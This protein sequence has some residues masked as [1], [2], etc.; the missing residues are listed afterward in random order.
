MRILFCWSCPLLCTIFRYTYTFISGEACGN[1]GSFKNSVGQIGIPVNSVCLA[2][3]K[4]AYFGRAFRCNPSGIVTFLRT[5]KHFSEI[6]PVLWMQEQTGIW[7][8]LIMCE[9]YWTPILQVIRLFLLRCPS[10]LLTRCP[11][12]A[13]YTDP[14]LRC[15]SFPATISFCFPFFFFGTCTM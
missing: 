8:L 12:A 1:T 6:T 15:I 9:R 2:V 14:L 7:S 3:A 13:I 4:C 10:I 11:I 5:R